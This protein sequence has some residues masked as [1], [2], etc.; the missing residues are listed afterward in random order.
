MLLLANLAN[1]KWCKKPE[2]WLK[3]WYM[4]THLKVC[5]ESY[6]INT[7][8]AGFRWFTK[9]FM[10]L[11]FGWEWAMYWKGCITLYWHVENGIKKFKNEKTFTLPCS[12]HRLQRLQSCILLIIDGATN[13]AADGCLCWHN[14][15]KNIDLKGWK[16]KTLVTIFNT[17][18]LTAAK[19][20]W[21]LQAKAKLENYLKEECYS[22]WYLQLFI[23]YFKKSFR[24]QKLLS[25]V[26]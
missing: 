15:S 21:R 6:P 20:A 26:S 12:C 14:F 2:K 10:S 24:I 16:M 11:C 3:P 19:T 8:M 22:E 4:G 9:Y 1:T 25:K 18:M 13:M 17:L 7:N 5:D 23:K